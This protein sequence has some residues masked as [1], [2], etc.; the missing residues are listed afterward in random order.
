M[1]FFLPA[2]PVVVKILGY[3]CR[4]Q[5]DYKTVHNMRSQ[6]SSQKIYTW[7]QRF[8]SIYAILSVRT[9]WI[10]PDY[11]VAHFLRMDHGWTRPLTWD[12]RMNKG[13]SPP[14]KMGKCGNFSQV[15]DPPL[16]PVW[17]WHVCEKKLWF[18]LHFRTLG[19]FLVFTKMFTFGWYYG[20]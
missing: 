6:S 4:H 8:Y 2:F 10:H 17:E 16:P 19:T 5:H 14:K 7:N 12:I 18:I 20:L 15:G 1:R 13:R 9:Y 11:H 3:L